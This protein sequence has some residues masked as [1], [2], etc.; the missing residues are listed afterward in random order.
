MTYSNTV[1]L[2][3]LIEQT[4]DNTNLLQETQ[5]S[6]RQRAILNYDTPVGYSEIFLQ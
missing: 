2:M 4:L 3:Q 5:L 6:Q 1:K